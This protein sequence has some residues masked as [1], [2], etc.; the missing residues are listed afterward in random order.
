MTK[1]D[2]HK[3]RLYKLSI[4]QNIRIIII[5]V[6]FVV[7]LILSFVYK[8]EW[9]YYITAA[10]LILIIYDKMCTG[11]Y[12]VDYAKDIH[13]II[14]RGLIY[15]EIYL[16]GKIKSRKA[17]IW[18]WQNR[19]LSVYLPNNVRATAYFKKGIGQIARCEFS[20]DTPARDI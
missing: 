9:I 12:T 17:F 8:K 18:D 10:L 1:Q 20:D 6:V 5:L 14:H 15:C 13:L 11:F 7:F 3:E 19:Y 2:F 16:N 4:L